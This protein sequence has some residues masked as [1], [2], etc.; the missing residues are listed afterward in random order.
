MK[1]LFWVGSFGVL[2]TAIAWAEEPGKVLPVK[3]AQATDAASMKPYK[4]LIEHTN[5]SLEL[6]P[7]PGGK[8]QMGSPETE[9][10]RRA[11]EGPVHEVEISPFWMGKY[12]ITWDVY[13][14]WMSDLDVFAREVNQLQET[15]RDKLADT[16]QKSQPTKPYCDMSFGMGLKGY[17]AICMTQHA[18]RTFCKW[19]TAK[20]GRYYRLP[21]EA[22]WEYACRAGTTSAYSFG[23]DPALLEEYAW[24][25][26]NSEEKYQKVGRKKP[27]PWGLYDMHG[28][29]AE[30]V[31]DE[32]QPEGFL[33]DKLRKKNPL[34]VPMVLYP[35]V[36]RGGG[37]DKSAAD[38]RSAAKEGST[39]DWIAQDPQVPV[40]IWYLTDALH[41]G[42]RVVRPLEEPTAEEKEKL[43]EYSEPILKERPVPLER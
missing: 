12:E 43:W 19:L 38:C 33:L 20:T 6:L 35:R 18:A 25:E 21:T 31:L 13:D 1:K 36:V 28:N 8:F 26:D 22:E 2:L 16:Y 34:L 11:D 40:S 27:N 23:D 4:E 10:G 30:W 9:P 32:H 14:V 17:P 15:T 24:F 5:A 39:E 41:V 37:W 29:V 42:F 7:I 3:D